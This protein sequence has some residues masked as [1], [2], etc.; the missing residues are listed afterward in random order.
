MTRAGPVALA[1]GAFLALA[2]FAAAADPAAPADAEVQR[3][4][5]FIQGSLDGGRKAADLWWYGWLY[6]YAGATAQQFAAHL[7]TNSV[8]QKQDTAVGYVT[9][10]F[11]VL[12]QVAAPV[13]AG[14]LALRLDAM[15]GETPEQRRV[16][17]AAGERFLRRAAAQ[18]EF[19]RS[20]KMQA[21]TLA[22]NLGTGLFV[23]LHYGRPDTDGIWFFFLGQAVSEVQIFTQP[24]RAVRDLRAYEQGSF[25]GADA[26]AGRPVWYLNASPG[27]FVLGCRF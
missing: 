24:M 26:R 11:G 6:G 5:D 20:W 14:R 8:K 22:V 9:G 10:A 1:A 15:P 12:G 18:E 17:L 3:R 2:T 7:R 25:G 21:I 16:K 23:W 4:L 27:G 13:Q 19:G